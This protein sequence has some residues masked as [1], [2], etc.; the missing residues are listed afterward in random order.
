MSTSAEVFKS[1]CLDL[2]V[3]LSAQEKEK[4]FNQLFFEMVRASDYDKAELLRGVARA[5]QEYYR[6]KHRS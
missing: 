6:L 4:V 2:Y 1:L 3:D 5:L